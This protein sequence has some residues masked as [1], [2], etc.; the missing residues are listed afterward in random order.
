[1]KPDTQAVVDAFN[2]SQDQIEVTLDVYSWS[3]GHDTLVTQISAGQAPDLANVNSLWDGE[4]SGIDEVLPLDDL[5]PKDFLAN[6]VPSGLQAFAIKGK[7]MGLP[8][9]LDPRAMYYRKDL[10]DKAG[11]KPPKTWD[12]VIAAGQALHKPP[13]MTG[14]GITFSRTSDDLDYWWYPFLGAVGAGGNVRIWTEDGHSRFAVPEAIQA[15]Q[16]LVDLAQKYK[17]TNTDYATGGRDETL[18]PLFYAGKLAM[19]ITGSWFPTLL[20]NNA[21]DL[22]V[23]I[24][25]PPVAKADITPAT[26][27]WPDCVIMF[28]QTK[29]PKEAAT[30]LQFMFGKD[31][32]LLFAKQRGV[33]PERIDVGQDPAYAVSDTEKFFVKSLEVAHNVYETPYPATFYRTNTEAETLIG[34]AVAGELTAEDAMKQAAAYTDKTNGLA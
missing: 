19:L 3:V 30:L 1:M 5:L 24:E 34:R 22:A 12:D 4:W 14:I 29:Q 15:T 20:K 6:F 9:F 25:M 2:K 23:G 21:P 17:V 27:F 32:R 10:F 18:Q 7:L 31:N 16:F 13:D 33:V 11:L 8:Y 28:K 26:G